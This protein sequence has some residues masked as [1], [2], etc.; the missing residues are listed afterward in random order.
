MD[1]DLTPAAGIN[2]ASDMK[3]AMFYAVHNCERITAQ[4]ADDALKTGMILSEGLACEVVE[5]KYCELPPK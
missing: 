1:V 4:I 2:R 5:Q 3:T